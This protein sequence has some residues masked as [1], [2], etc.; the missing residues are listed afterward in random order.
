[1][2][3]STADG[4][5]A[6]I[7]V[8]PSIDA[9]SHSGPANYT[10]RATWGPWHVERGVELAGHHAPRDRIFEDLAARMSVDEAEALGQALIAA[11]AA[12]RAHPPTPTDEILHAYE[13]ARV[14][15]TERTRGD[16]TWVDVDEVRTRLRGRLGDADLHTALTQM[17]AAGHLELDPG[18]APGAVVVDGVS[19]ARVQP[20]ADYLAYWDDPAPEPG[21]SD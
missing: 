4:Y 20:H 9:Y 17:H 14:A 18:E 3:I 10:V 21:E 8:A 5:L 16:A 19:Y 13:A 15:A 11:A 6:D 7:P 1:M 12:R 2:I